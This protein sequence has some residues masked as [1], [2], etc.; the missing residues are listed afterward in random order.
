MLVA[1]TSHRLGISVSCGEELSAVRSYN[2]MKKRRL[3]FFDTGTRMPGPNKASQSLSKAHRSLVSCSPLSVVSISHANPWTLAATFASATHLSTSL[4]T[5]LISGLDCVRSDA[6]RV[7]IL[8]R[9]L[10]RFRIGSMGR[11]GI[12]DRGIVEGLRVGMK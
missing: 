6:S 1:R 5:L 7:V 3:H 4:S 9:V 12:C 10:Y 11:R 8:S 2:N